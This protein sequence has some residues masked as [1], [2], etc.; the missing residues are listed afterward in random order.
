[1]ARIVRKHST[2][3]KHAK[4]EGFSVLAE[5]EISILYRVG[6]KIYWIKKEN[7]K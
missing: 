5:T 7:L 3:S 6:E 4:M 1:M 2:F